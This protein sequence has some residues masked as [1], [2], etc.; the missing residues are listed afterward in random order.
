MELRQLK[1]FLKIAELGSFSKASLALHIA[2]PALSQR[3]AQLEG[4]LG[5]ALFHRR[6]NGVQMTEHGEAFFAHAQRVVKLV[7]DLP[8]AVTRCRDEL[9]GSVSLGLPQSSAMQ[10][11]APLI[12]ALQRHHPSIS[13]EIYEELSGNLLRQL[14]AGQLDLAILVNDQDLEV[15]DAVM[16]MQEE[17]FLA[18]T[19]ERVLGDC[20]GI[21]QLGTL[22]LT[23]PGQRHGVRAMVDAAVRAHGMLPLAPSIVANSLGIMRRLVESGTVCSVLTWASVSD[24]V[25]A[26]RIKL[27]PL[28]PRLTRRVSLCTAKSAATSMAAEAVRD[29]LIHLTRDQVKSGKWQGVSPL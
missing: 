15:V 16:L 6:H 10:F 14:N 1:Y 25:A 7:D 3:M 28:H 12:E 4:E 20:V 22:P 27:T 29:L 21:Q 18:S 19:P 5:C 2:Q 9:R 8:N 24:S 26:R 13:L 23:L 11:A 17:L